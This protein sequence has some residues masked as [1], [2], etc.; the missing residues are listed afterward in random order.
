[1]KTLTSLMESVTPLYESLLSDTKDK[2]ANMRDT[3]TFEPTK[4]DLN[5]DGYGRIVWNDIPVNLNKYKKYIDAGITD[6]INREVKYDDEHDRRYALND[7]NAVQPKQKWTNLRVGVWSYG[8]PSISISVEG[9]TAYPFGITMFSIDHVPR[10]SKWTTE[11]LISLGNTVI[12]RIIANPSKAIK[13]M[14][15]H[16]CITNQKYDYDEVMKKI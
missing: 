1:M 5:R 2:V 4:I 8:P 11:D 6:C 16:W 15:S 7:W 12:H 3:L 13:Y 10:R 9:D 14:A